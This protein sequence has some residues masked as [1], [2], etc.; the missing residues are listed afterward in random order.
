MGFTTDTPF[1]IAS[2]TKTF[3]ASLYELSVQTGRIRSDDTV[4]R[5]LGSE[6][7]AKIQA[8]PLF[9]LANYTSGLPAD[10][11]TSNDT[12]PST[13][14]GDYTELDMLN[15]LA[16]PRFTVTTPGTVYTYSNLGFSLLAVCLQRADGF[17]NGRMWN[18]D[19][20]LRPV[21]NDILVPL[22]MVKTKPYTSAISGLLPLGFDAEGNP[23]ATGSPTL[24]AYDGAGGLV[25]TPNDMMTWLQ[26][27][28]GIIESEN[29]GNVLPVVQ[30]P[31]ATG[32]SDLPTNTVPGLGWFATIIQTS[33]G[34]ALTIIEKNGDLPGFSSQIAFLAPAE[35]QSA[36]AGVFVLAN[37]KLTENGNTA[38]TNIAYELLVTMAGLGV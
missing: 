5:F 12:Y 27:N 2:I 15:F 6:V 3:T 21:V 10:N 11:V 9:D 36:A 31:A 29:L 7:S 34:G 28:M 35:C 16:N 22:G 14:M 26:F 19:E 20:I 32:V 37:E 18:A 30:T 23:L 17:G 1:E 8:I 33:S 38:T 25:S 4:G 24:P 13:A